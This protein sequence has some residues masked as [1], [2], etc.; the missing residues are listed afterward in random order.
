[1]GDMFRAAFASHAEELRTLQK[2][3]Q[4]RM[5]AV[6]HQFEDQLDS[7]AAEFVECVHRVTN[8]VMFGCRHI[9]QTRDSLHASVASACRG[10]SFT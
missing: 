6:Q 10:R 3:Q 1:M 4:S 2:L 5:A 8:F 9:V 7:M